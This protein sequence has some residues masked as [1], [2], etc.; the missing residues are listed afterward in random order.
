[1]T[2]RTAVTLLALLALAASAAPALAHQGNPNYESLVRGVRPAVPGL[3]VQVLNFDDRLEL[4]NRSGKD[5]EVDGYEGEPYVRLMA[6]GRVLVNQ[7]S[8]ATYLNTERSGDVPL[9]PG[10]SAKAA[11][12]W[13]LVSRTGRYEFHDHRI[14]WMGQGDPPGIQG[15]DRR[16]KVFDW[17]VPLRVDGRRATLVGSLWWKG[18]RGGGISAAALGGLGLA[19]LLALVASVAVIRRRAAGERGTP[20]EA[21]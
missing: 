9:P 17:R 3:R 1:M 19:V 2:R 4:T 20:Q 11:P 10:V 7:R 14:H 5:V 6:D 8:P 13:T 15:K 18:P 21:W 12:R 16:T